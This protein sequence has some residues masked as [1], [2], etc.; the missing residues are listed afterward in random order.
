MGAKGIEI[1]EDKRG[2]NVFFI[3][4]FQKGLFHEL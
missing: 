3:L 1:A 4:L 2:M